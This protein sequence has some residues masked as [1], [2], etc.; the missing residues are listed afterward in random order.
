M[1]TSDDGM[2][3][4]P[5]P[6][7]SMGELDDGHYARARMAGV[8]PQQFARSRSRSPT[9][10]AAAVRRR[11][12][13]QQ[14]RRKRSRSRSHSRSQMGGGSGGGNTDA[15]GPVYRQRQRRR[16]RLPPQPQPQQG[17]SDDLLAQQAAAAEAAAELE[18]RDVRNKEN[19]CYPATTLIARTDAFYRHPLESDG[20][21]GSAFCFLCTRIN[22]RGSSAR[23]LQSKMSD[24]IRDILRSKVGTIRLVTL[25]GIIHRTYNIAVRPRLITL[26]GYTNTPKRPEWSIQSIRQHLMT[27]D[28]SDPRTLIMRNLQIVNDTMHMYDGIKMMRIM[29]DDTGDEH[30]RPDDR[31]VAHIIRLSKHSLELVKCLERMQRIR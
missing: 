31:V 24:V 19:M 12:R 21:D 13:Q 3:R 22:K 5:S 28:V 1:S 10:A 20:G 4:P 27:H 30:L 15:S 29:D 16:R 9:A 2:Y 17:P 25:I 8:T 18:A 26:H 7:G 11:R 6:N 14:Q 23:V